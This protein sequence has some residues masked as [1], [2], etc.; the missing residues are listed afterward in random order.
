MDAFFASVEQRDN[1]ELRGKAIAVGGSGRRG[2]IA[3]ASYEARKFGIKSAMPGHLALKKYPDL[4]FVRPRFEAYKQAS[5]EIMSIFRE[6]SELVEPIAFDEA[7]ID[8]TDS[9]R[10]ASVI[11]KEMKV[12]IKEKT[13]LTASAGVSINKFLAKIASDY[14]KP[15]GFKVIKPKEAITFVLDLP[16]GKIPGIGKVTE[17]KMKEK[18]IFFGKDILNLDKIYLQKHFGKSGLYFQDLL[19]FKVN[20]PVEPNRIRKSIGTE[21]TFEENLSN[22]DDIIENIRKVNNRLQKQILDNN[23][24]ARTVTLKIKYSDFNS[25]T[26]SKTLNHSISDSEEIFSICMDLLKFPFFPNKPIRLLGVQLSNLDNF[27]DKQIN[28]QLS[29]TF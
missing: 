19:S 18:G 23:V 10:P 1:P 15:N 25:I 27:Q 4:I 29:L 14:N 12:R 28:K 6:Y 2:V 11:A 3:A 16:I 20:N 8:V 5:E 22:E 17:E 24:N 21:R 7:Y 9:A 13:Q 26:R